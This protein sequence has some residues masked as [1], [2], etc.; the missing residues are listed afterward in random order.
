MTLAAFPSHLNTHGK[1]S[2][3][4]SSENQYDCAGSGLPSG[5]SVGSHPPTPVRSSEACASTRGALSSY[6]SVAAHWLCRSRSTAPAR[7]LRKNDTKAGTGL[8][9]SRGPDVAKAW[10]GA[11]KGRRSS[12]ALVAKTILPSV[13]SKARTCTTLA[14]RA[15][16][17]TPC[18]S[19]FCQ[20]QGVFLQ[21]KLEANSVG[22]CPAARLV[23]RE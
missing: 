15:H 17:T 11:K 7:N 19:S 5:P 18:C 3:L 20:S 12:S 14:S 10:R 21:K 13:S 16:F 8:T 4:I 23:P 6:T 22:H 9:E 1:Y 2:A